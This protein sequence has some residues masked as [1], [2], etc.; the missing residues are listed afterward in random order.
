[1]KTLFNDAYSLYAK[2][3]HPYRAV[4]SPSAYSRGWKRE[5]ERESTQSQGDTRGERH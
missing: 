5:R 3:M 1:M 4:R 2:N